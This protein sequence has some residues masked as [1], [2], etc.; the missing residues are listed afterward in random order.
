MS[1]HIIPIFSLYERKRMGAKTY[2]IGNIVRKERHILADDKYITK[3]NR[4][5]Y[6]T[7]ANVYLILGKI[8]YLSPTIS[9]PSL[10]QCRTC[11]PLIP[12]SKLTS[13]MT[14]FQICSFLRLL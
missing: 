1:S 3:Q 4:E 9:L 6:E 11:P 10:R 7:E 2:R 14:N 5:A 12:K 8:T 13:P